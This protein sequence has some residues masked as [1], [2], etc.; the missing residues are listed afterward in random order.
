MID[1]LEG[2]GTPLTVEMLA[3]LVKTA[4]ERTLKPIIVDGKPYFSV[5]H[6][7]VAPNATL[8]VEVG[9]SRETVELGDP[10]EMVPGTVI[11][12]SG[13]KASQIP[14]RVDTPFMFIGGGEDGGGDKVADYWEKRRADEEFVSGSTWT[15]AQQ[16]AMRAMTIMRDPDA[17]SSM[18][19]NRIREMAQP[20][21]D[22]RLD[23]GAR[24]ESRRGGRAEGV[25]ER[26]VR[27]HACLLPG[28]DK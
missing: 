2:K 27:R 6:V 4:K 9:D 23:R 10:A 18:P 1:V 12:V 13:V 26:P 21:A 25:G 15:P 17:L 22:D 5:H 28:Y 16:A 8:T 7:V 11:T 19:F 14:M 20:E 3:A 24:R